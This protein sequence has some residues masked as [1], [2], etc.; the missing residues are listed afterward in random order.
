[1]AIDG[2]ALTLLSARNVSY[3][4]AAQLAGLNT[5]FYLSYPILMALSSPTFRCARSDARSMR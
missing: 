1:V 3:A 4:S 5:G 2:W